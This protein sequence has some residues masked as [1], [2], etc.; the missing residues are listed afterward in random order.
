MPEETDV[1]K[2]LAEIEKDYAELLR[3]GALPLV[4]PRLPSVPVNATARIVRSI[5]TYSAYETPI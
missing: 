4:F 2:E 1:L 5:T 3:L